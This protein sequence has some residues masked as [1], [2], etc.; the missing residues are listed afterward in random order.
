[1]GVEGSEDVRTCAR[2]RGAA[3]A[4]SG[5]PRVRQGDAKR[6]YILWRSVDVKMT[7]TTISK[8]F[9]WPSFLWLAKLF[10]NP[11]EPSKFLNK[12]YKEVVVRR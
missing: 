7:V 4:P 11:S 3:A 5:S 10:F 12:N 2:H 8:A 6:L 9:S 1:M